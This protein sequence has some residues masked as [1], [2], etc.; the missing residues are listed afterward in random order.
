MKS[1]RDLDVS[2]PQRLVIITERHVVTRDDA[3]PELLTQFRKLH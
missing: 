3:V 2:H 1:G